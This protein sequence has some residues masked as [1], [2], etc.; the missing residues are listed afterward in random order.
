MNE[1][2]INRVNLEVYYL[3]LHQLLIHQLHPL[4]VE[5]IIWDKRYPFLFQH[6]LRYVCVYV[7]MY[8]FVC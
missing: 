7:Y 4:N 3:H 1:L 6:L 5:I 8:V 2:F